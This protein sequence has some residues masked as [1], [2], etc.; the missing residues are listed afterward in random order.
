MLFHFL[1]F[2][3]VGAAD[4]GWVDREALS[5]QLRRHELNQDI[6]RIRDDF[7]K[8]E[9]FEAAEID[10]A[11]LAEEPRQV[12]GHDRH[13]RTRTVE[14]RRHASPDVPPAAEAGVG[15]RR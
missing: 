9:L 4:E 13:R 10:G 12:G 7:R 11:G 3:G 15:P 1:M 5:R 8:L 2:S 6:R 14:P